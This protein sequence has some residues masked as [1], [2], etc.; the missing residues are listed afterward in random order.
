MTRDSRKSDSE[1]PGQDSMN[2]RRVSDL[3]PMEI[4]RQIG[5][6]PDSLLF[7]RSF[8]CQRRMTDP[9]VFTPG[10]DSSV[11]QRRAT[12]IDRVVPQPPIVVQPPSPVVGTPNWFVVEIGDARVNAFCTFPL[13]ASAADGVVV[14]DRQYLRFGRIVEQVK[15]SRFEAMAPQ[16][17]AID[18]ECQLGDYVNGQT[19]IATALIPSFMQRAECDAGF[20]SVETVKR[21]H[22]S[23][24]TQPPSLP[25]CV[26][27]T[28]STPEKGPPIIL[29]LSP[30]PSVARQGGR[31]GI[32]PARAEAISCIMRISGSPT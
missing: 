32:V 10:P 30:L 15:S 26:S 7:P 17:V 23:M 19:E 21:L 4:V 2:D 28:P 6:D 20:V 11:S 27:S 16:I 29:T 3:L 25:F 24:T 5:L 14:R 18:Q 22:T 12:M 31:Q 1:S 13:A 9:I 8:A